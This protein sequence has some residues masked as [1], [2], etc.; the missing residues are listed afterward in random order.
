M[1]PDLDALWQRGITAV[2]MGHLDIAKDCFTAIVMADETNEAAWFQLSQV[3]E[4]SEEQRICLENVLALNPDHAKAEQLLDELTETAVLPPPSHHLHP[5]P[6]GAIL[7]P[8]RQT[9]SD[10]QPTPEKQSAPA[11]RYTSSSQF[12]DIWTKLWHEEI[13][14]CAYCA[15]EVTPDQNICPHCQRKL[16]TWQYYQEQPSTSL[17]LYWVLITGLG[18]L[19]FIQSF[20]DI[21][22]QRELLLAILS[23]TLMLISFSLAAAIY[24][25]QLWGHF[26]TIA[27]LIG[28]II[29]RVTTFFVPFSLTGVPLQG[30]DPA[31]SNFVG[32]LFSGFGSFLATMQI[33]A[34]I[35]ALLFAIM[36][37]TPDFERVPLRRLAWLSKRASLA[38]DYHLLA[39]AFAESDMWA[40]AVLHWQ[41]AVGQA[42]TQAIYML[43][44]GRAYQK[45]GFIERSRDILQTALTHSRQPEQ[46]AA[47]KQ[48]L[49]NLE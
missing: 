1:T 49:N 42:P 25:R 34:A 2:N 22:I 18:Q 9:Q 41:H 38:S 10:D 11:I 37:A 31:I 27:F 13:D 14:I 28:F 33:T 5:S 24:W 30:I 32:D 44:L 21:V 16:T 6:A 4:D 26:L 39:K 48:A 7:Y 12:D 46:Q 36:W 17:H 3:V 47:I 29:L 19:F 23:V 8:E 45:L 40:T 43:Y 15:Q 35:L 20:Y